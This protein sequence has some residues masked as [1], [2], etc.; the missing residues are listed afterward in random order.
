MVRYQNKGGNSGVHSYE[1][2]S[3]SIIVIFS[4]GSKY[5]YSYA[6]PGSAEVEK[7]KVLAESGRGLNS[8]ISSIIRKNY[9]KKLV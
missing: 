3:D 4:D 1:I 9:A 6:R 8:Y 2:R 7:M 5:L